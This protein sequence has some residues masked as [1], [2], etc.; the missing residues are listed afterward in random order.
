MVGA[1]GASVLLDFLALGSRRKRL[2]GHSS[3]KR[4]RRQGSDDQ[5]GS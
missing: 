2:W 3:T 1:M 5:R 4:L